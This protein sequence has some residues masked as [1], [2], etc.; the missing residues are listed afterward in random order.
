MAI[1]LSKG[2][3]ISLS[4]EAGG[5]LSKL[6]VGLGWDP[7]ATD[8]AAFD[9]DD[10]VDRLDLQLRERGRPTQ[11]SDGEP[12]R[13]E[14]PGHTRDKV[15]QRAVAVPEQV[16]VAGRSVAQVKAGEGSATGQRPAR[17]DASERLQD[18]PLRPTEPRRWHVGPLASRR[19]KNA[20]WGAL[21]RGSAQALATAPRS[22]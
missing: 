4:K 12:R 11:A 20:T 22:R 21:A 16:K 19:A 6:T 17:L 9:L 13:A 10:P 5:T 14:R 3:N 18:R 8:G 15:G 7:R 2:G 1:S